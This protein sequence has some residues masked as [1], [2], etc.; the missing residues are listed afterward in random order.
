MYCN[1]KLKPDFARVRALRMSRFCHLEVLH[2]TT[3]NPR[4]HAWAANLLPGPVQPQHLNGN[5]AHNQNEAELIT[6]ETVT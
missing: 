1:W 5:Y 3:G 2:V 6:D 4:E